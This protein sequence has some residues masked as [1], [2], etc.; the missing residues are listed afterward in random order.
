[1]N[2]NKNVVYPKNAKD[3]LLEGKVNFWKQNSDK[4]LNVNS[5]NRDKWSQY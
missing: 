1:M 3:L 4:L 2:A 5:F